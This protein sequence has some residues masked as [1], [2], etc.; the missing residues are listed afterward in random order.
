MK[1]VVY[2]GAIAVVAAGAAGFLLLNHS[3]NAQ[4]ES[5]WPLLDRYCVDCHNDAE[6]TAG[7]SFEGMKPEDVAAKAAIFER[8]IHKLN[9]GVMPPRQEPQP[10]PEARADGKMAAGRLFP[11]HR[12]AIAR[13]S[14]LRQVARSRLR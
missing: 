13:G 5:Q 6:F 8:A 12:Q 3:P 7:I 10:E 1:P 4:L 2:G 14:R 9:I 11:K